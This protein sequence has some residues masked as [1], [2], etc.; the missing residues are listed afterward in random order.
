MYEM[1]KIL[2]RVWIRPREVTSSEPNFLPHQLYIHRVSKNR[3]R[4]LCLITLPKNRTLP[5]IF[6]LFNRPSML[7]NSSNGHQHW[8]CRRTSVE[9]KT[10]CLG[11]RVCKRTPFRTFVV[12]T[13]IKNQLIH[14]HSNHHFS[15]V[16]MKPEYSFM[17][18]ISTTLAYC[19][20]DK[21]V[22]FNVRDDVLSHRDTSSSTVSMLVAVRAV[23]GLPLPDFL[24]I[25]PVCFK[26]L[27]ES[28]NVFFFHP[29]AGNSFI[30]LTAP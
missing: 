17:F 1:L 26:R 7:D 25:D 8:C 22:Q 18:F 23:F 27:T 5:I 10:K 28:F 24:V 14:Y 30:S 11:M 29:L 6:D 12:S 13:N 3:T 2:L 9:P 19:Y 16:Q 4:L 20:R 21:C 15:K